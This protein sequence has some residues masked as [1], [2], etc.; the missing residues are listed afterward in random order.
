M[1]TKRPQSSGTAEAGVHHVAKVT[2]ACNCLFNLT[3][4]QNDLGNDGTIEFV[5]DESATGCCV[6]TQIK[7]GVSYIRNG[8]FVLPADEKHFGYWR[9][10]CLPVCG[11]VYD[12]ASDIAKW[13][14][15]TAH[16][17]E[18]PTQ[19]TIEVPD[20]NIFDQAN[21]NE[22]RDHFLSYRLRFSDATNFGRALEDFSHLEDVRRCENGIRALF[23]FHRN[24]M[25]T[26]YY[27]ISVINNFRD[28][29]LLRLLIVTLS[30]VP[31]HGDIFWVPG[32]NTIP[33]RVCK[34]A[35][36]FLR[37]MLSRDS[38]VTFLAAIGNQGGFERGTIGQCVQ[39]IISL[40]PNHRASLESII[41]DA[42]VSQ[43][44]RYWAL[45]RQILNE[46]HRDR[47]YCITITEKASSL[48]TDED[49][50]ECVRGL[51]ETLRTPGRLV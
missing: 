22:F 37:R 50:Q 14:D 12:P 11:L 44:V 35:E 43:D 38:I 25:E 13:V 1:T 40:A 16:V 6:A 46:Q 26:W 33:E 45:L 36:A 8:R 5:V 39:A 10:H 29:P 31:G 17:N 23:S 41:F 15:I 18:H 2:S 47:P 27:V 42:T 4:Q 49:H 21:F 24:R 28:H 32:E 20:G 19:F 30:H 48:F 9:G 7:S 3:A 34:D 51:L